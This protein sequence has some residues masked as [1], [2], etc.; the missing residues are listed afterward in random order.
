M[1]SRRR[2]KICPVTRGA[3]SGRSSAGRREPWR[4]DGRPAG[5]REPSGGKGALHCLFI[6]RSGSA[7]DRRKPPGAEDP[8]TGFLSFPVTCFYY[9]K[10]KG[11][12]RGIA[13][14]TAPVNGCPSRPDEAGRLSVLPVDR[15]RQ[16][17][18]CGPRGAAGGKDHSPPL[19]PLY[20]AWGL[21]AARE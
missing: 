14:K 3:A 9:I 7:P 6:P 8:N 16:A 4:R 15:C 19:C 13:T 17:L 21:N 12:R 11:S 18:L 20:S 2:I 1:S 10:E 5:E